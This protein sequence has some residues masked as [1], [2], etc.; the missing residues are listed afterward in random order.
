MYRFVTFINKGFNYF[1]TNLELA[2]DNNIINNSY[3]II[4]NIEPL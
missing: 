2:H 3:K 1:K 4:Q